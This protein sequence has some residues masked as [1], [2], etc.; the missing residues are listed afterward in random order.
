M[1]WSSILKPARKEP[2]F[3]FVFLTSFPNVMDLVYVEEKQ[4]FFGHS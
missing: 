1:N 4:Q 3:V 2:F